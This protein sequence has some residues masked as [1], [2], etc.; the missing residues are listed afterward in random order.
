[1]SGLAN[2]PTKT[3]SVGFLDGAGTEP[4]I[5]LKPG[6]VAY[7]KYSRLAGCLQVRHTDAIAIGDGDSDGDDEERAEA[8]TNK[9]RNGYDMA[10]E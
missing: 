3:N 6:P 5:Q 9:V 1:M 7:T 2:H 4:F 8:V 10:T